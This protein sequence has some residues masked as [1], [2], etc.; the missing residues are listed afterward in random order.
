MH[1]QN[2]G[3]HSNV[4]CAQF[5][6]P[7][8]FCAAKSKSC[9]ARPLLMW[10]LSH[11]SLDCTRKLLALNRRLV[12]ICNVAR[13]QCECLMEGCAVKSE[14]EQGQMPVDSDAGFVNLYCTSKALALGRC[15]YA[16]LHGRST[17][18]WWRA[19]W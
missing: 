10:A 15:S 19:A 16:T 14:F 13:A 18:A 1:T 7:V 8:G 5:E 17:N 9:T 3:C 2:S 6:C 12:N 4:A 11:G